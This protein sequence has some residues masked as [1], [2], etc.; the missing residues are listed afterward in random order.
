M[1][2]SSPL[3]RFWAG[4]AYAFVGDFAESDPRTAVNQSTSS[5][6]SIAGLLESRLTSPTTLKEPLGVFGDRATSS[7]GPFGMSRI[8]LVTAT[9]RGR[10]AAASS[11]G[12]GD[13][14]AEAAR[15]G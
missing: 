12:G 9:P 10:G 4:R 1:L 6:L 8:G 2:T 15:Q 13:G 14:G 7:F 5:S 11:R 3:F